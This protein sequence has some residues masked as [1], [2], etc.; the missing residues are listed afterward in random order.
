M[1][2]SKLFVGL[3]AL[4]A[5]ITLA[6]TAGPVGW[7]AVEE[8]PPSSGGGG[9]GSSTSPSSALPIAS[10]DALRNAALAMTVRGS[11]CYTAPSMDWNFAGRVTDITVSGD[12]AEQVLRKL[13]EFEYHFR[14]ANPS[15]TVRGYLYLYDGKGRA[16][17]YSQ[18]EWKPLDKK[19]P[20]FDIWLWGVPLL[21]GV[22]AAEVIALD[23]NGATANRHQ[24]DVTEWGQVLF[25]PSLC[26]RPNGLLVATLDDGSLAVHRLATGLPVGLSVVDGGGASYGIA[27]H[28]EYTDPDAVDVL[29]IHYRPTVLLT[30][31]K[32]K[33]VTFDVRGVT[34]QDGNTVLER[35]PA[36][37][38]STVSGAVVLGTVEL[39]TEKPTTLKV[40]AG[41]YRLRFTG[42]KHF[43][44]PGDLWTGS[45]QPTKPQPAT[46]SDGGEG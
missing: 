29:E 37:E 35:P 43:R 22:R 32:T 41:E 13:M 2:K 16:I 21:N 27:G 38:V 31:S 6:I 10:E 8:Q 7:A 36:M 15:D 12:Y 14:L 17:F 19:R 24:L 30:V 40:D 3:A 23:E 26:G 46:P 42:W 4:V 39:S 18:T 20:A 34:W 5:S 45:Q 11:I 9:G 33:D 28:Y 1:K 25:P 44:E